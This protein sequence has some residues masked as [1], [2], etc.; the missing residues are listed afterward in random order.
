M[1]FNPADCKAEGENT[2]FVA[3]GYSVIRE[4][5][6]N[7]DKWYTVV[8]GTGVTAGTQ[9]ALKDAIT[10]ADTT[11][12]NALTVKLAD[13]EYTLYNVDKA[14]TQ[15]TELTIEGAGKDETVFTAGDMTVTDA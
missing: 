11:S 3:P 10:N 2:N 15:N 1:N 4:D 14:K 12:S 8:K 9:D 6:A 7:G 5:K 13:G